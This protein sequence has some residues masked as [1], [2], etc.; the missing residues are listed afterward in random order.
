MYHV[1]TTDLTPETHSLNAT[2][3]S[4]PC[5]KKIESNLWGRGKHVEAPPLPTAN[6][7]SVSMRFSLVHF[8]WVCSS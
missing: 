7:V 5:K 6:T 3:S 4:H 8:A 2:L 1:Q